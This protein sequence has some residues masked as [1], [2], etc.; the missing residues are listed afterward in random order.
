[1]ERVLVVG[2]WCAHPDSGER[3]SIAQAMRVLQ[4]E[5]AS[6]P[7]LQPQMYRSVSDLAG[8]GSLSIESYTGD[9]K[10]SSDSH[11][12]LL[13]GHTRSAPWASATASQSWPG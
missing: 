12:K 6:L 7:T 8:Y 3:P 1:M 5:D 13:H 10:P 4:F 9:S 11:A 2:L